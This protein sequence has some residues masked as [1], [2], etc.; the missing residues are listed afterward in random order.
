MTWFIVS[1][2]VVRKLGS[3]RLIAPRWPST[4]VSMAAGA[5]SLKRPNFLTTSQDVTKGADQ[6]KY[7]LNAIY[8][9]ILEVA[10][11]KMNSSI[12][13]KSIHMI[14]LASSFVWRGHDVEVF[15]VQHWRP[16]KSLYP[17]WHLRQVI[18]FHS[19]SK[20]LDRFLQGSYMS[21]DMI[22][23]EFNLSTYLD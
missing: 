15:V 3:F 11:I 23:G 17:W 13:V 22:I 21:L 2:E 16:R 12:E 10:D 5:V 19:K 20:S 1:C 8:K 14:G 9:R 18:S 6:A 7:D 4:A